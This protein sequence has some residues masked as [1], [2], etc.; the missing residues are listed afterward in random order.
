MRNNNK[1]HNECFYEGLQ[2]MPSKGAGH[3]TKIK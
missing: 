1:K 2:E 3:A